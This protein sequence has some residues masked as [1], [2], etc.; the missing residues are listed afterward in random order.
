MDCRSIALLRHPAS[1]ETCAFMHI[2]GAI[3]C[4]NCA[5]NNLKILF[6]ARARLPQLALT[7]LK[8]LLWEARP[9]GEGL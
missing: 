5:G 3:I 4:N 7:T 9:R 8:I 6:A 1:H 2:V